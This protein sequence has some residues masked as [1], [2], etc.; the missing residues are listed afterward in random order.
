[1]GMALLLQQVQ[2]P[3][4]CI[5]AFRMEMNK[6]NSTCIVGMLCSW[7]PC[8]YLPATGLT[9][10]KNPTACPG[11]SGRSNARDWRGAET[12]KLRV[13][14]NTQ[15]IKMFSSPSS[16]PFIQLLAQSTHHTRLKQGKITE[17]A[18]NILKLLI[19][20]SSRFSQM[21][22]IGGDVL[23]AQL[24]KIRQIRDFEAI[25]VKCA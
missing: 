7:N 14:M 3:L 2:P 19:Y 9:S 8:P 22:Y 13:N 15:F 18:K 5:L 17:D 16:V 6:E 20:K 1:M 23:L 12:S 4:H 24:T 10:A 11:N 25:R 21:Q